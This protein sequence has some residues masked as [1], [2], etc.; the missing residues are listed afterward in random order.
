[1]V[2]ITL[3][4]FVVLISII[5]FISFISSSFSIGS[6]KD[7]IEP[8]YGPGEG[9]R[10]WI[11]ISLKNE[12]STSVFK[13]ST[14]E[15]I[16]LIELLAKNSNSGFNY[17][18]NPVDCSS[19]YAYSSSETSK[20]FSLNDGEA[21]IVGFKIPATGK[22]ITGIPSF[23]VNVTSSSAEATDLPLSIDIL[24]DQQIEWKAH[25]SSGNFGIKDYGCYL[26]SGGVTETDIST[27]IYCEKIVIP[28]APKLKIG[29]DLTGSGIAQFTMNIEDTDGTNSK[30]CHATLS[31]NGKAE[32]DIN[33]PFES[34]SYFVCI[35]G[36]NTASETYKITYEQDEPCGFSGSYEGTYSYD[37]KIFGQTEKYSPV[38]S[39]T[40]NDAELGQVDSEVTDIET[41]IEDYLSERY[42]NN[43]SKSCIIPIRFIGG[44]NQQI[45]LTDASLKYTT[46]IT[47]TE[48][49]LYDLEE[50]S[51]KVSSGFQRL[52]FD[53]A[54]FYVPD[55]YG[56]FTLSIDIGED[57]LLS[58]TVTVGQ[59]PII[60][61]LTP[62]VTAIKYPTKFKVKVSWSKNI[63]KY[64][65]SFG[66]GNSQNTTVN[67]ITY[68]YS[69]LGTYTLKV[70][71]F[72]ANGKTS[73]K[74]FDITVGPVSEIV[75]SLLEESKANLADIKLQIAS[76][77]A[78]EQKSLE[79]SLNITGTNH[80]LGVIESEIATA[81][82]EEDYEKIFGQL[83]SLNIPRLLAKTG[84]SSE[85][86]FYPTED[87]IDLSVLKEIGG[88]E[89]SEEEGEYKTAVLSWE[90]ENVDAKMVFT[91]ISA[92]Y[93]SNA[94]P[95][96]NI[97]KIT[98]IK[99]NLDAGNPYMIIKKMDNLIF[100]KSYAEEEKDGYIYITLSESEEAIT[101]STTDDVN[102]VNL[103]M[104]ISPPISELTVL[105]ETPTEL[106][107]NSKKWVIF[108][109][110][111]ALIILMAAV[112][113]IGLKM[114]YKRKYENYLFKNRNNLY[115]IMNY[116]QTEKKKGTK[117]KDIATKLKKAG[118]NSEQLRYALRKYAGKKVV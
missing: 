14:G 86:L 53:D 20:S 84:T 44:A 24:N 1:M 101:F 82:T 42:D 3:K 28:N 83:L 73:S 50:I 15:E 94:E 16:K 118:W 47:P 41:Y 90:G 106:E 40:L 46:D 89:Y 110:V 93:N 48:R 91:E 85:I 68:T 36:D 25:N 10:G 4:S 105:G 97:F 27:N 62:T 108:G 64:S 112:V 43:C 96:M 107:K 31:G 61:E 102:F 99:K 9:I 95:F 87:N 111:V 71:V 115:N 2:K 37:F 26:E 103:P 74:E 54:K 29:A 79:R 51:A 104:F 11:N 5:F 38:G 30:E 22:L 18:C 12:S 39:F 88:G 32:C 55:D 114:W 23:S 17:V 60:N 6:P 66:D 33:S 19:D 76:F 8:L 109:I 34:G 117:E 72:D 35:R 92:T 7:S 65:W 80:T 116:V 45:T 59:L 57:N 98:A 21:V 13:S 67:E 77:S 113:W 69:T 49:D 56:N 70:S 58:K 52:Y 75:P 63:T 100:D 81:T 78:F